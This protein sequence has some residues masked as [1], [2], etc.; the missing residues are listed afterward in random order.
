MMIGAAGLALLVW[1]GAISNSA[2]LSVDH[3]KEVYAAQKCMMCHSIAGTGNKAHTLDG[4][5]SK[6]K[7]DELKKFVMNPKETKPNISMRAYSNLPEKDIDDLVAYLA[8]LKN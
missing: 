8:T 5:G 6:M 1:I 2:E 4:I 3:G 7:T